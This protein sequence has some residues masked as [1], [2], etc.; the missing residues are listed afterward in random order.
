MEI[1]EPKAITAKSRR[2]ALRDER[3][4]KIL[5]DIIYGKY[6]GNGRKPADGSGR[7]F[8]AHDGVYYGGNHRKV[9]NVKVYST[10]IRNI[11][12]YFYDQ[13]VDVI[14]EQLWNWY[15]LYRATKILDIIAHPSAD[16]MQ[17][18]LLL[19]KAMDGTIET[20]KSNLLETGE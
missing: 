8:F 17:A 20:L 9:Q 15:Q 7:S 11:S 18:I 1:I 13:H 10:I 16:T 6:L 14:E 12:K 2:A 3:D 4:K 19:R 5:G